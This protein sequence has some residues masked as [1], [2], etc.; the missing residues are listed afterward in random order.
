LREREI[1]VLLDP[2]RDHR[3]NLGGISA[4][5]QIRREYRAISRQGHDQ[6][7]TRAWNGPLFFNFARLIKE[8]RRCGRIVGCRAFHLPQGARA[9]LFA[10]RADRSLRADALPICRAAA[11][12]DA[13]SLREPVSAPYQVR[14]GLSLENASIET[15]LVA[16]A[17]H[18]FDEGGFLLVV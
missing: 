1:S 16:Q 17:D 14:G 6:A 11:C 7:I 18:L 12:L 8:P 15:A 2:A 9:R 5:P 10:A 4:R 3:R 13:L